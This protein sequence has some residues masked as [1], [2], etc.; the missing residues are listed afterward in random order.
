MEWHLYSEHITKQEL[1]RFSL[2]KPKWP[3]NGQPMDYWCTYLFIFIFIFGYFHFS[4]RARFFYPP[5]L[6]V[7][8]NSKKPIAKKINPFGQWFFSF[9]VAG[10]TSRQDCCSL[11]KRLVHHRFSGRNSIRSATIWLPNGRGKYS[12]VQF[13]LLLLLWFFMFI[14]IYF[15]LFSQLLEWKRY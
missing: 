2:A 14:L 1:Q 13:L 11:L 4:L 9:N 10:H 6:I 7:F 12:S 8:K 15:P 5:G 3:S